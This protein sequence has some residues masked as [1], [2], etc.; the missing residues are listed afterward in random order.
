MSEPF[1]GEIRLFGFNF[2]PVGW[3]FCN[4]QLLSI[5]QN[6]A[7]FSLLGTIYGGNGTSTFAL[8]NL[9]SRV[10]IH[11]G[12]GPGL[13]PYVM[14]QVA[15]TETITLTSQQMPQHNHTVNV[16]GSG[17]NSDSPKTSVPAK[18]SSPSYSTSA[19]DGSTMNPNMIS[20]AGNSQPFPIMQP[21]LTVNFCIAMQGIFPSRN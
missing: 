21:Y 15:G 6:A 4:G 11:F 9:Q 2:A 16:V 18:T 17:G 8:P 7:L 12:Q 10:P 5:Q 1:L 19:P 3:A 13:S 14:G 20:F